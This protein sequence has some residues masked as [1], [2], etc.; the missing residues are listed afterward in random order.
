[1]SDRGFM[2]ER[3]FMSVCGREQLALRRSRQQ[4]GGRSRLN[5]LGER[6]QFLAGATG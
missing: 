3:R 5:V 1:M 2:L 4:S 6:E